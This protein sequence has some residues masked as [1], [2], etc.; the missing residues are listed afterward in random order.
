[1]ILLQQQHCVEGS[2]LLFPNYGC[3]SGLPTST[4]TP[5]CTV[6]PSNTISV[7]FGAVQAINIHKGTLASFY[8]AFATL[9]A[10]HARLYLQELR[11]QE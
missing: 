4:M 8:Q 10:I 7:T 1:M 2:G 9:V 6:G 11:G 5:G 3:P